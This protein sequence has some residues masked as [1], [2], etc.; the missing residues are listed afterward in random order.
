[1]ASLS[2]N[3]KRYRAQFTNSCGT[4]FSSAAALTVIAPPSAAITTPAIV[5]G[6]SSGNVA[7]VPS[8]GPG[9]SYAWT[10][11]GGTITAGTGT[12]SIAYTASSGGSINISVTVSNAFGCSA[13]GNQGV[14]LASQGRDLEGWKNKAPLQ[15]QGSTLNK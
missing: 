3:G 14:S 10:V 4:A 8:A 7:S 2:D 5:C 6:N 12:P 11:S 13:S 15:G 1:T 9:A